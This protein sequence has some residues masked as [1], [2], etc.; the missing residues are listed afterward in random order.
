ELAG[1]YARLEQRHGFERTTLRTDY[2]F[3]S[4]EKAAE[5]CRFFFGD[6]LAT[7]ILDNRWSRV[8]EWTGLW[9]KRVLP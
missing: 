2:A 6:D 7:L 9:S 3:A 4:P 5:S 8:P 1:Y